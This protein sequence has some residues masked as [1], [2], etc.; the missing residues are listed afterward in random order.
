MARSAS[1]NPDPVRL[2]A[3]VRRACELVDPHDEDSV[4]GEFEQ[5][6]E[7]ADEPVSG[8]LDTLEERIGFGGDEDPAVMMAQAVVLYLAHRRDEVDDEPN[9]VLALAAR[10]EFD[11]RPPVALQNWLDERGVRV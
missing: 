1:S 11:G 8:V 2:S 3:L 4:V 10:A 9:D 7:D 6:Y 5:R